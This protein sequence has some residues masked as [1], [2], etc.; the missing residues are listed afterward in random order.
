MWQPSLKEYYGFSRQAKV[1]VSVVLPSGLPDI[2]IGRGLGVAVI[3]L[4]QVARASL[5]SMIFSV[6]ECLKLSYDKVILVAWED[7]R[8]FEDEVTKDMVVDWLER[9]AD[10]AGVKV[11]STSS[12]AVLA[13]VVRDFHEHVLG[14]SNVKRTKREVELAM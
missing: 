13:R 9:F 7:G 8:E 5:D 6:L 12:A 10:L 1:P 2:T 14:P 3:T 11:V 4:S